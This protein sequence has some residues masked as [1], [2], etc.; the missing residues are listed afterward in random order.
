MQDRWI[1]GGAVVFSCLGMALLFFFAS[2]LEL[3]PTRIMQL[4]DQGT[5]RVVGI[6]SNVTVFGASTVLE[7]AQ[8]EHVR[9]VVF[10]RNLTVLRGDYVE[11]IGSLDE[12]NGSQQLLA[13]SVLLR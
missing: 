10:E 2:T 8:L 3:E 9:V 13:Q 4:P 12:Q 6:V 11:V 7:V 5:V 1:A